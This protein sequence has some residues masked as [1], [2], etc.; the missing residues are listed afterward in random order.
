[1]EKE[2]KEKFNA[3]VLYLIGGFLAFWFLPD[4]F[5][6]AGYFFAGFLFLASIGSY[7][8][9]ISDLSE[10]TG[11]GFVVIFVNGLMIIMSAF[12]FFANI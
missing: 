12:A 11:G 9:S 5:P 3:S 6:V 10:I 4:F 2:K 8:E 1:M 7:F